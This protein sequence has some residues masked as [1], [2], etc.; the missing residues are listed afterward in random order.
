MKDYRD[1]EKIYIGS[2]DIGAVLLAGI[3]EDGDLEAKY[4]DF[5]EDDWYHAY[6]I[7]NGEAGFDRNEFQ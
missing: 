6:L 5:H 2:S 1:C 3:G 7:I 4:L